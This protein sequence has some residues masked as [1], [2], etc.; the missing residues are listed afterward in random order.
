M[1]LLI[2]LS[3][4]ERIK[5]NEKINLRECRESNPGPIAAKQERYPL[6]YAAPPQATGFS[7]LFLFYSYRAR[8]RDSEAGAETETGRKTEKIGTGAG[9][10]S[11][12]RFPPKPSLSRN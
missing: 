12:V 1:L 10:A 9:A 4:V 6:S 11:K 7:S 5:F 3:K 2:N 8:R